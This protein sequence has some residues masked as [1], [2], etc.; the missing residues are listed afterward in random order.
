MMLLNIYHLVLVQIMVL[1]ANKKKCKR[2]NGTKL[3]P[4]LRKSPFNC[5]GKRNDDVIPLITS[6]INQ[7]YICL[8]KSDNNHQFK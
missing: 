7:F 6:D 3:T 8:I 2:G 5:P 1:A 4:I